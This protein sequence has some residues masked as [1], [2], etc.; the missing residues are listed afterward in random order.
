M[1]ADILVPKDFPDEL[2]NV[3]VQMMAYPVTLSFIVWIN[4]TLLSEAGD[5]ILSEDGDYIVVAKEVY[6]S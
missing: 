3:L 2:L 4:N 1:Q 5:S 6:W